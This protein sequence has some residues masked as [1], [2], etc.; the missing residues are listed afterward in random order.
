MSTSSIYFLPSS[1][2]TVGQFKRIVIN[3]LQEM[4]LIDG[5]YDKEQEQFASGELFS[6][7]YASVHDSDQY[8]LV[9]EASPEIDGAVCYK[10]NK[11]VDDDIYDVINDHYDLESETGVEKDMRELQLVCHHCNSKQTLIQVVYSQPSDQPIQ[12]ANQF[13]QFVDVSDVIDQNL[14]NVLKEKLGCDLNLIHERM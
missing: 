4:H 1:K 14:V 12:F 5:Y 8:R 13:F 2:F 7:E 9:P 11:N 6:F 10:C 3:S